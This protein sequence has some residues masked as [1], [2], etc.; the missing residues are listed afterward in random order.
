MH[1]IQPCCSQKHVG[2]LIHSLGDGGTALWHGMGDLSL[3]EVGDALFFRYSEADALV[4][5]PSVPDLVADLLMRWLR[6]TWA[7][8]DGKGSIPV[9]SRLTLIA[10]LSEKRSPVASQWLTDNPFPERLV[11]RN[12]QQNNTA[13]ILPDVA[14]FGPVNLAY[15]GHFIATAT[16]DQK[17]IEELK[18]T[19]MAVR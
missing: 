6:K 13:I 1:L 11:L 4:A 15:G 12:V 2:Q 8:R 17:M 19:L 14:L 10:S 3:V 7:T 9:F 16:R 18:S 5:C